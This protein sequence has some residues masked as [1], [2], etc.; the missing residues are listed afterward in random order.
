MISTF[1]LRTLLEMARRATLQ[2]EAAPKHEEPRIATL[3][4]SFIPIPK[5]KEKAARLARDPAAIDTILIHVTG[6]SGG[7]GVLRSAVAKWEV[8]ALAR[9]LDPRD[10]AITERLRATPY[11]GLV[12][13]SPL[14]IRNRDLAQRSYHGGP[15][16]NHA[17]GFSLDM[18][19]RETMPDAFW[20]AARLGL[21]DLAQRLADAGARPPFRLIAHRQVEPP[22]RR[23]D[24]PGAIAWRN[25]V[26]PVVTDHPDLLWADLEHQANGGLP[27][28]KSWHPAAQHDDRGRRIA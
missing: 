26:I 6:V 2:T 7:F 5:G 28:P 1:H 14:I 12:I 25:T 10:L 3:D 18:G 19:S 13:R 17:A 22:N 16:G 15:A 9:K 4:A 11:H 24:D 21:L 8:E 27:I 23:G 20:P